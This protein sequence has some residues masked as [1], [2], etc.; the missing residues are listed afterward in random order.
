MARCLS[1]SYGEA[2]PGENQCAR[3]RPNQSIPSTPEQL[4]ERRRSLLLEQEAKLT[5]AA[6][7]DAHYQPDLDRV[8][9][10]LAT[11]DTGVPA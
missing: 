10:E 2:R 4:A 9:A 1:C 5:V 3:C 6:A 8:R 7:R 11:L